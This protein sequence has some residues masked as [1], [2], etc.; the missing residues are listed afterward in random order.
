[1][2][3]GTDLEG[4]IARVELAGQLAERFGFGAAGLF[5]GLSAWR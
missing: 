5:G 1:L 2:V 4:Q 3:L